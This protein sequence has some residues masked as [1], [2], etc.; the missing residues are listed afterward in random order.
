[1]RKITQILTMLLFKGL[2]Q[3]IVIPDLFGVNLGIN[4]GDCAVLEVIVV[5]KN[6]QFV[7]LS[8]RF[9]FK[10]TQRLYIR[11]TLKLVKD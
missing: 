10:N 9:G 11:A 8:L 4:V 7:M 1:M 2:C 6:H 5:S 3:S